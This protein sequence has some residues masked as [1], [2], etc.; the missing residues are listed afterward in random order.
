MTRPDDGITLGRA[1]RG[2]ATSSPDRA[3]ARSRLLRFL[4][5]VGVAAVAVWVDQGTKA[6]V[7]TMGSLA[8]MAPPARR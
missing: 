1:T 8:S 7:R 6:G 2:D 4:L 3:S 5:A